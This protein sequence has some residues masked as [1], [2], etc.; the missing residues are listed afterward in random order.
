[1]TRRT[2]PL[3]ELAAALGLCVVL[4]ACGVPTGGAPEAIPPSDLPGALTTSTPGATTSAAPTSIPGQPLVFLLDT[5]D[6]LVPRSRPVAGDIRD[7][8][9]Q[10]LDAL[11]EGPTQAERRQGLTTALSAQARITVGE[12]S[13]GTATVELSSGTDTATGLQNR[14]VVAQ[15]VLT[16]T[17]LPGIEGVLLTQD[18]SAVEAPL[19]TGELT[20]RPLTA[21]DYSSYLT[22]P[23]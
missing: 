17:S 12:L 4:G 7:Q 21:A 20:T 23:P 14:R 11:A 22:D 2:T 1:M 9:E 6:V 15:V 3:R 10:L 5:G 18:G 19:P 8:A 13:G 16:V